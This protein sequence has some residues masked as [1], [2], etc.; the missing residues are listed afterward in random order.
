MNT[1]A[2]TLDL[3]PGLTLAL[4]LALLLATGSATADYRNPLQMHFITIPA[5][6]FTMGS[7]D[8]EAIA[9]QIPDGNAATLA[10]ET[11]AHRVRLLQPFL[12]GRTEV[13]QGQWLA[14][15]EN[16]PGP[17]ELWQR[18]DWQQLP[19]VSVSW[20]MA[21]RFTEELS[22]LDPSHH[23]RLPS[24]AEWEY[25][26]RAGSDGIYPWPEDDIEQHAWFIHNS[27]DQPQPV[28]SRQANA[29]GLHDMIGNAWE[30]TAD[31]Y[32]P[33]SYANAAQQQP[34]I[35]PTGPAQGQR[36][37]RRGGSYHCPL[38]LT[39]VAYRAPDDPNAKYSVLG[40]RVIAEPLAHSK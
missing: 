9:I 10:D 29:F 36:K 16:R 20:P 18:P 1:P 35:N 25:A 6:E 17:S 14:V 15:M 28:A 13:T 23:Y 12:L 26:A 21:Q 3:T 37:V 32:S 40:F 31:W 2:P 33:D 11:P 30:W 5:G 4:T 19:V 38:H 27:G 8:P 34:A 39:R 24:E 7:S 22:K